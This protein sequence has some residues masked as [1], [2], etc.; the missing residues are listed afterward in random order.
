MDKDWRSNNIGNLT[1]NVREIASIQESLRPSLGAMDNIRGI[2]SI[3]ESLRSSIGAMDN[4]RGIGSITESLR[5]SLGVMDNIRGIA[6]I[7]ESLRSSIGA[8][9]NVRGIGSIQESLRPSSGVLESMRM[10]LAG[11]S[12]IAKS[13]LDIPNIYDAVNSVFIEL[14]T[15]NLNLNERFNILSNLKMPLESSNPS[16]VDEEIKIE[17][18]IFNF[19]FFI[20]MR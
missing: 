1:N 11:R 2:S 16:H 4:V 7:Q 18:G 13:A 20:N 12:E 17:F 10:V 6:T 3:Q 15:K 14:S 8:M 19:D 9:E 5:P